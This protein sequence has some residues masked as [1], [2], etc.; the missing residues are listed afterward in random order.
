VAGG[1]LKVKVTA[2]TPRVGQHGLYGLALEVR[3]APGMFEVPLTFAN[4]YGI[5]VAPRPMRAYLASGRGA[6]SMLASPVGRPGKQR[7]DGNSLKELREHQPGDPFRH[8]AWR[9]S[10]RRGK[11][12]VRE[13][14]REERDVV[15]VVLEATSDLWS[16]PLGRAPLDR[17]VD[18]AATTVSR[19]LAKGDRVGLALL[20]HDTRTLLSPDGGH[21]HGVK[22]MH[23]LTTGLGSLDASRSDL[24][25]NDVAARVFEHLRPLDDRGLSD[26]GRNDFDRLAQRADGTRARAPFR[27]KAPEG[28]TERDAVLRRYL[29][30][31]GIDVPPRSSPDRDAVAHCLL[32]FLTSL[33]RQ[34]PRPSLVHVFAAPLEASHEEELITALGKLRRAGATIEWSIPSVLESLEPTPHAEEHDPEDEERAPPIAETSTPTEQTAPAARAV[35]VRSELARRRME[36]TLARVGVRLT[37]PQAPRVVPSE[38]ETRP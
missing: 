37:R 20:D 9:A 16:G 11:L 34:R 1:R 2:K 23:A 15:W 35:A 5:E 25:E 12:L 38:I 10:A 26:V 33:G 27:V 3:G 24:D 21:L 32:R 22:L 17:M 8:I 6:A 19:H 29:A 7:G 30:S 18:E 28:R 36:Q 13:H 4:P 31:F 14:E